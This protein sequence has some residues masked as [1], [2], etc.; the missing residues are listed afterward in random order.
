MVRLSTSG[1]AWLHSGLA[2]LTGRPDGPALLAP[3]A[4]VERIE[5][6]GRRAGV[7][8]LALAAER[9]RLM[10]LARQGGTSCGGSTRLLRAADGWLGVSLARPDDV[11][12]IPAWLELDSG[13][14]D[15]D[16]PWA[17]VAATVAHRPTAAVVARSTLL[18]LP[19]SALGEHEPAGPGP[20]IATHVG[21]ASP[22]RR[23]PIVLDLSSLWA[24]PLCG[25]ILAD[26]GAD[27][28]KVEST[29]RPDAARDGSPELFRLLN[30]GKDHTTLDLGHDEG[31]ARL[32]DLVAGAD[33]VIE[34]SRPRAL[35]QM[36][37]R[38]DTNLRTTDGPRVWV[39]ITGHGRE[40]NRVGFGDDASVAGGLVAWDEV[41]PCFA[42]DA[43]AD[44]LAGI[45][46][47]GLV[48]SALGSGGRWLA[49]VSLAGVTASVAEGLDHRPWQPVR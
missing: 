24:G 28:L 7:D 13:M 12:A 16:D 45:A 39:S 32:R 48:R 8:A 42:G 38:A 35:A 1:R 27:V 5:A 26:A 6:L 19:V 17:V 43:I 33:V 34:S 2:D 44:P 25:A 49:D 15:P 10:E 4:P 11:A 37:I 40:A 23:A 29:S 47:A 31:R 20:V 3:D 22:L 9:G 41:G 36:G 21:D 30:G 14:V 46:A 18:S